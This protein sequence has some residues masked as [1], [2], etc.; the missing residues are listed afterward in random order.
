[1]SNLTI[2]C[3]I[4]AIR[5]GQYTEIVVEDLQ[6]DYTDDLKFVTVVRLPN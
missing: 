2:N 5:E 4:V 6:R 3:K 1:M